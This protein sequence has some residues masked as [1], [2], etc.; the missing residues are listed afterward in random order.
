ML[1][2]LVER[3]RRLPE[4]G[5]RYLILRVERNNNNEGETRMRIS[6]TLVSSFIVVAYMVVMFTIGSMVTAPPARCAI[7]VT[8]Q[9]CYGSKICGDSCF[10]FMPG[11]PGSAGQC[12][13]SD[14]VPSEEAD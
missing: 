11:P 14:F 9:I 6:D 1:A 5:L 3:L 12:V 13:S 4:R 7:C 2:C 10:C 8:S